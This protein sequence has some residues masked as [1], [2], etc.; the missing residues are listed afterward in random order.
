M[1]T[2][3]LAGLAAFMLAAAGAASAQE[4]T[5]TQVL[6]KVYQ[7]YAAIKDYQ[8][9][10]TLGRQFGGGAVALTGEMAFRRPDRLALT[11]TAQRKVQLVIDGKSRWLYD[12]GLNQ[13]TRES[14]AGESGWAALSLA[15]ADLGLGI[16]DAANTVHLLLAGQPVTDVLVRPERGE[17]QT[18]DGMSMYVIKLG[19]PKESWFTVGSFELWVGKED[20][21]V[22]RMVT[23]AWTGGVT[24]RSLEIDE[25]HKDIK[26][27]QGL[28]DEV[29]SFV[30]PPGAKEVDVLGLDVEEDTLVGEPA[31]DVTLNDLDGKQVSLAGFKGKPVVAHLWASWDV[32][33][34]EEMADLE[35]IYQAGKEAGLVAVGINSMESAEEVKQAVKQAKV[36]YPILL[37]PEDQFADACQTVVPAAVYIDQGGVVRAIDQGLI[38]RGRALDRLAK[39]GV[40]ITLG[41]AEVSPLRKASD[42]RDQ[43]AVGFLTGHDDTAVA[44]FQEA[45]G[46]VPDDPMGWVSLGA[47]RTALGQH[48]EAAKAF[49]KA[50]AL[51]P[52]DTQLMNDIALAY[53]DR[54]G[55]PQKA[56]EMARR[57]TDAQPKVPNYWH[58][59][60][61]ALL[62]AADV[63]AAVEALKT[64]ATLNERDPAIQFAL[65]TAYEKQGDKEAALAAY[66][67]ARKSRYPGAAEAV[68]RL[69]Q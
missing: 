58:T 54:G 60:G 6:D 34:M 1:R 55:P 7:R 41:A 51:A 50:L 52:D 39:I 64:A 46:V 30:P 18:M 19:R 48:E 27:D 25:I 36:S 12:G 26:V 62:A 3:L 22:H 38:S 21:L 49:E 67:N 59:L 31:P 16:S 28:G 14:L 33:S 23:R 61:R 32:G 17:D 66:R 4:P 56:V 8:D 69:S 10:F 11:T 45:A 13:Y 42:L 44:R 47:L 2:G 65:G 57:A 20:S 15:G 24:G 9:T 68:K 43:G 37:D 63:D 35:A 5:A 29:F 40:E 53:L